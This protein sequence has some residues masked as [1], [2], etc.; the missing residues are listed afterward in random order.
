MSIIPGLAVE[1]LNYVLFFE[2]CYYPI[3]FGMIGVQLPTGDRLWK[4]PGM[5]SPLYIEGPAG[6]RIVQRHIHHRRWEDMEALPCPQ[7]KGKLI[8][9]YANFPEFQLGA[10]RDGRSADWLPL[11]RFT[12]PAPIDF[13]TYS[14]AIFLNKVPVHRNTSV[15]EFGWTARR[16]GAGT[17][18]MASRDREDH[19]SFSPS[20]YWR[21][22][23]RRAPSS[24]RYDGWIRFG[25]GGHLQVNDPKVEMNIT[26]HNGFSALASFDDRLIVLTRG[27]K[28]AAVTFIDPATRSTSLRA[29]MS[30]GG[31][32][33]EYFYDD[34]YWSR[35]IPARPE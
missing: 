18:V 31:G 1:G 8:L 23:V 11:H 7:I 35:L 27:E 5:Y 15:T 12:Y 25:V 13:K 29:N 2:R 9:K 10:F 28:R 24:S 16:I 20:S 32:F 34:G 6:W 17:L 22:C 33:E 4:W 14:D 30:E 26:E 3:G 19:F 21:R